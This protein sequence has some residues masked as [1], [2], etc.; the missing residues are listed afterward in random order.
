MRGRSRE[1][2]RERGTRVGVR[3]RPTRL[4]SEVERKRRGIDAAFRHCFRI[5]LKHKDT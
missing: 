3:K 1:R 5:Y 2:E 4:S